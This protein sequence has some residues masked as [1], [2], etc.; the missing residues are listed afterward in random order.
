MNEQEIL[1]AYQA[2]AKEQVKLLH[3][4]KKHTE[5]AAQIITCR[6]SLA[7]K[8]SVLRDV[9]QNMSQPLLQVF[10]PQLA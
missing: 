2:C 1:S 6:Q 4:E 7:E 8:K 3:L 5:I 10:D 9:H